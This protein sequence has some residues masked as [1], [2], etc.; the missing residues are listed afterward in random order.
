MCWRC[1]CCA[2]GVVWQQKGSEV[3][4][5]SIALARLLVIFSCSAH[6]LYSPRIS[7][8]IKRCGFLSSWKRSPLKL[9]PHSS[10]S[11]STSPS[12]IHLRS[13]HQP[14][15][16]EREICK[17][18]FRTITYLSRSATRNLEMKAPHPAENRM[19]VILAARQMDCSVEETG[20]SLCL[21]G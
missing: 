17:F 8:E 1:K 7:W 5:H 9:I 13:K 16:Y 20:A 19:I 21:R 18:G 15:L 2:S 11:S 12:T 10:N 4:F 14:R 3:E 6:V